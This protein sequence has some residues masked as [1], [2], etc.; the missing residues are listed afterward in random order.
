MPLG[1]NMYVCVHGDTDSILVP[2]I[3]FKFVYYRQLNATRWGIN[4]LSFSYLDQCMPVQFSIGTLW[5]PIVFL[6]KRG[7][8][9]AS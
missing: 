4:N 5:L 1:G 3:C 2:A 9:T 8:E 6:I 7:F